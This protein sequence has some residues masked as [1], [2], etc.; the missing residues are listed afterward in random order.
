MVTS[1]FLG[2]NLDGRREVRAI[3]GTSCGMAKLTPPRD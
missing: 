2:T 3:S 1:A